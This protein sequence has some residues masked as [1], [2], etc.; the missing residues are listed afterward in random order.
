M[1]RDYTL[2]SLVRGKV[3]FDSRNR[4]SVVAEAN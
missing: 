1:G 3:R 4:V 2:F